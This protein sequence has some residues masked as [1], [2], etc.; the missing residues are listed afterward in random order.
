MQGLVELQSKFEH[1]DALRGDA[2]TTIEE[3]S[4]RFSTMLVGGLL[5]TA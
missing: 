4:T 1:L 3:R 2:A 5:A